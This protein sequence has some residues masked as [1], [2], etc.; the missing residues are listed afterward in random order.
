MPIA[1][2]LGFPR[3]GIHPGD[4]ISALGKIP[5]CEAESSESGECLLLVTDTP[6]AEHEASL[7]MQ[8]E[9]IPGLAGL[10]LVFAAEAGDGSAPVGASGTTGETTGAGYDREAT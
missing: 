6:D 10:S 5:H 1:S 7:R 9:A 4:L 3:P 2:Y 8:L